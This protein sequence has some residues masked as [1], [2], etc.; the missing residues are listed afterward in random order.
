MDENQPEIIALAR[1]EDIQVP[2]GCEDSISF[3]AMSRW[4]G[5][6]PL[7]PLNCRITCWGV[8]DPEASA[9]WS[10]ELITERGVHDLSHHVMALDCGPIADGDSDDWWDGSPPP[11]LAFIPGLVLNALLCDG[12]NY[13][14]VM[15]MARPW[16]TAIQPSWLRSMTTKALGLPIGESPVCSS[17]I[18]VV[19]LV[20]VPL[21]DKAH[22]PS[23]H[24]H[25]GPLGVLDC[26]TME[27][28]AYFP[29]GGSAFL[30][31]PVDLGLLGASVSG[32][33]KAGADRHGS[34]GSASFQSW[35]NGEASWS[36]KHRCLISYVAARYLEVQDPV[37]T[38]QE[39]P[40]VVVGMG[41]EDF[42]LSS[43]VVL[44]LLCQA[45]PERV[46]NINVT[47]DPRNRGADLQLNHP[48]D[49]RPD[50]LWRKFF[51][52]LGAHWKVGKVGKGDR[53]DSLFPDSSFSDDLS[54]DPLLSPEGLSTGSIGYS[55]LVPIFHLLGCLD[56]LDL[57]PF[58]QYLNQRTTLFPEA[59]TKHAASQ[60]SPIEKKEF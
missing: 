5:R 47:I 32:P 17:L 39:P 13:P 26:E 1:G 24:W 10:V 8:Y 9:C 14:S 4:K 29:G 57:I 53:E 21:V 40:L 56:K 37:S 15:F 51:H 43:A 2:V 23:H 46:L 28:R 36:V 11:S 7:G 38:A 42:H 27:W 49:W 25:D 33:S 3:L 16:F 48:A 58:V 44:V 52:H 45:W 55:R 18:L 41:L 35:L 59:W 34:L 20:G 50:S 19:A 31:L 54:R 30:T 6:E 60:V 12:R 22:S